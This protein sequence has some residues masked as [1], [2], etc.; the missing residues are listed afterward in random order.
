MSAART[1]GGVF[2]GIVSVLGVV[3]QALEYAGVPFDGAMSTLAGSSAV[4]LPFAAFA[5]GLMSGYAIRK[6]R[7]ER[8]AS[9]KDAEIAVL[10]KRQTQEQMDAALSAKDAAKIGAWPPDVLSLSPSARRKLSEMSEEEGACMAFMSN[11]STMKEGMPWK[12]LAI[13]GSDA[14]PEVTA[15]SVERLESA[16]VVRTV[17]IFS[18]GEPFNPTTG[19]VG[20]R[21]ST[22]WCSGTLSPVSVSYRHSVWP[23]EPIEFTP[24]GREIAAICGRSDDPDAI[25]RFQREWKKEFDRTR[26][27]GTTNKAS[28]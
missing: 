10:E 2:L 23:R 15:E 13:P 1:I 24:D 9:A 6:S 20:R 11:A 19:K 18:E 4:W 26:G 28:R 17:P 25:G 8:E 7:A 21:V 27:F 22:R 3:L 16:G 12:A 5:L 14:Y